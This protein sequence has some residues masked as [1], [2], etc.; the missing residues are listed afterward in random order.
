MEMK[1][2]RVQ[3][4]AR[5]LDLPEASVYAMARENRLPGVVRIG[6]HIR[7]DPEAIEEF[8][9]NGGQALPG[10]WKREA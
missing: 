10:G 7:F 6:R 8:I 9:K 2:L 1:L 3:H 4:V 5:R